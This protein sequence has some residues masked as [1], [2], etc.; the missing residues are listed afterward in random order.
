MGG[1]SSKS[2]DEDKKATQP[3]TATTA[4]SSDA[5][6]DQDRAIYQ[7]RVQKDRLHKYAQKTEKV[8][9]REAAAA[10]ELLKQALLVELDSGKSTKDR[11]EIKKRCQSKAALIIKRKKMQSN[12]I[13]KAYQQ[14]N[15]LET[16]V[17]SIQFATMSQQVFAALKAGNQALEQ[18]NKETSLEEVE[19]LMDD[20]KEAIEYQNQIS[21]LLGSE[22]T[23]DDK[24]AAEKELAAMEAEEAAEEE[25]LAKQL[26]TAPTRPLVDSNPTIIS[27]S[28]DKAHSSTSA[29]KQSKS[30][31][32]A[33][34][35]QM[36]L[37]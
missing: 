26:P 5:I 2:S 37:S 1:R 28:P 13:D 15:N 10:K 30:K 24:E 32:D 21:E 11:E 34:S 12:M 25:R 27:S 14:M 22:L 23:N 8:L 20:T 35:A 31:Q 19:K 4:A 18:I 6:S 9:E 7:L 29:V 33:S 16:L 36:I 3:T 17:H